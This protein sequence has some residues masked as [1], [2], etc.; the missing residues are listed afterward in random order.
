MSFLD[1]AQTLPP[2]Q[3]LGS[4][5]HRATLAREKRCAAAQELFLAQIEEREISRRDLEILGFEKKTLGDFLGKSRHFGMDLEREIKGGDEIVT[6]SAT[7]MG[8]VWAW[9]LRHAPEQAE[10]LV[11]K[12]QFATIAE[13]EKDLIA[14]INA[15]N[16]VNP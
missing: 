9:V 15:E 10:T 5:T 13:F 3:R 4:S 8:R 14:R 1:Y 16:V 6:V 2:G 12:T 7:Q 11:L